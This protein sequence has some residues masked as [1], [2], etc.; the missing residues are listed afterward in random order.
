MVE[1]ISSCFSSSIVESLVFVHGAFFVGMLCRRVDRNRAAHPCVVLRMSRGSGVRCCVVRVVCGRWSG[2]QSVERHRTCR[3][4][5]FIL[6]H[7]G[8][9]EM[10]KVMEAVLAEDHPGSEKTLLQLRQRVREFLL[11]C[12]FAPLCLWFL[13]S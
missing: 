1:Q 8:C 6:A 9:G 2:V 5:S 13:L 12:V 3:G 4:Q 7:R 11:W 10:E